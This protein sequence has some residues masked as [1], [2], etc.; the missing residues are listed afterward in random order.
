M[1]LIAPLPERDLAL[2]SH[3]WFRAVMWAP[4][5]DTYTQEKKWEVAR[6][7]MHGAYKSDKLLPPVEDPQDILVFLTHHFDL[8]AKDS[9]YQDEPIKDVLHALAH[10]SSH[11]TIWDLK[12]FDPTDRKSVV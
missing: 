3:D 9:R 4:T 8:T 12:R 10:A 11:N 6:L 2:K 1:E 7:T 5:S